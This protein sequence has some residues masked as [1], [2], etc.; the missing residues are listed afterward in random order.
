LAIG[1]A[2][3]TLRVK[4]PA[5]P[6]ELESTGAPYQQ[7]VRPAVWNRQPRLTPRERA[8][9]QAAITAFQPGAAAPTQ[10]VSA[11]VI[12]PAATVAESQKLLAREGYFIGRT[13]GADSPAYR[14]AVAGYLHDHP[15]AQRPLIAP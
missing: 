4:L 2:P 3:P 6:S 8:T 15:Q 7:D 13:D 5:E 14:A 12:A 10:P 9:A 11:P 1:K